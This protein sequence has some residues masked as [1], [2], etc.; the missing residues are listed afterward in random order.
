MTKCDFCPDSQL[1]NGQLVCPFGHCLLTKS[2]ID[3]LLDKLAKIKR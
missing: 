2:R 3:E 1:I